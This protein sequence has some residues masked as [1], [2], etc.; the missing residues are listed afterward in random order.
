MSE[1]G[2]L[3]AILIQLAPWAITSLF[4][5]LLFF[6]R[7]DRSRAE[8]IAVEVRSRLQ[9]IEVK[10]QQVDHLNEFRRELLDWMRR[11]EDK[12]DGKADK[13]IVR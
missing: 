6:E 10:L 2:T 4:G 7:R 13:V 1:S 5:V 11:I 8:Q 9:A 12:L 3:A